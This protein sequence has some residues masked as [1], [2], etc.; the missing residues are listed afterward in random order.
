M[1]NLQDII[2]N[3]PQ[4]MAI[5][6][7]SWI[8]IAVW[9]YSLI[10]WMVMGEIDAIFGIVGIGVAFVLGYFSFMPPTEALRPFTAVATI[11]TVIIFPILRKSLNDREL[12]AIDVEAMEDA[13][14]L[15][16]SKPENAPIRFKLAKLLYQRGHIESALA[17]GAEA[18]QGMP[19]KHFTEEHRMYARWK[20]MNPQVNPIKAIT[21]IDCGYANPPSALYCQGCNQPH[22][23]DSARGLIIGRQFGRKLISGWIAGILALVGI[24]L[25]SALPPAPAIVVMVAIMVGAGLIIVLAL[26]QPGDSAKA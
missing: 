18:L 17:I 3:H 11:L 16:R 2:F 13:Y 26:R 7:V 10:A 4:W 21:C 19:E 20:R 8:A 15:L 23:L 1:P 12:I 5:A 22:L 25:A 24:P 14:E 9:V 6:C